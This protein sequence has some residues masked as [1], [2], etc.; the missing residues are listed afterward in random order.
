VDHTPG[1]SGPSEAARSV[2]LAR[3]RADLGAFVTVVDPSRPADPAASGAATLPLDGM[4]FAAKDTID[5]AGVA[6]SYGSRHFAGHVPGRSA[7]CIELLEAAGAVLVGKTT[8]HEFACSANGPARNPHD[9]GRITGGS[10][11]GSAAALAAGIV[12][13]ALGT[14]TGGSARIP[15]ALCGVHGFKPTF[16]ALPLDGVFPLSPTFDTLGL[17]ARDP[18]TIRAAWRVLHPDDAAASRAPLT[19]VARVDLGPGLPVDADVD[20]AVAGTVD[21]LSPTRIAIPEIG[22]TH[23]IYRRIQGG[24]ARALHEDRLAAAPELFQPDVRDR[25]EAAGDVRAWEYVRA[26]ADMERLRAR[27]LPLFDSVDVLALPTTPVT[28]PLLGEEEVRIGEQTLPT[29]SALLSLTTPWSVLGWPAISVPAGQVSGLPVGLQLVAAPGRD[30]DLLDLAAEHF[31][32]A[33]PTDHHPHQFAPPTARR[34]HG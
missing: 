16:G 22:E 11:A 34:R 1:Q 12:P 20:S 15:A 29:R 21:R 3:E 5:T 23:E 10:S 25:L 4:P 30:A 26:R 24:E 17:M 14:D 19:R 33:F 6:T 2:G 13:L 32:A 9:P 27:L 28:A 31:P 8:T 18:R 7:S